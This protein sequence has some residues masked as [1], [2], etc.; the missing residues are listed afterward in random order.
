MFAQVAAA[1]LK[2]ASKKKPAKAPSVKRP[3]PKSGPSQPAGSLLDRLNQA[4]NRPRSFAVP[5]P[6]LPPRRS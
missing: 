3:A 5:Q 1:A 4:N 2:A 6:A